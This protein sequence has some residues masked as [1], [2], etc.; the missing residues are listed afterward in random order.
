MSSQANDQEK[1]TKIVDSEIQVVDSPDALVLSS[2][3][4]HVRHS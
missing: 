1:Q 2:D 4:N 3:P